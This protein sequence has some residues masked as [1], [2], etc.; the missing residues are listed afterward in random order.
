MVF[1]SLED[2][3]PC[4]CCAGR[5][6]V[7]GAANTRWRWNLLEPTVNSPSVVTSSCCRGLLG[8]L[9]WVI[10]GCTA[11]LPPS[12]ASPR[13]EELSAIEAA[14]CSWRIAELPWSTTC[15]Q[16]FVRIRTVVS[17]PEEFTDLCGRRPVHAGGTLYACN[18]EQH[19]WT[20][21]ASLF[22]SDRIPLLVISRLQP[23]AHRRILVIHESMHWLERCSGK[24]IDFDH[25]DPRVWQSA[26]LM[27]QHLLEKDDERYRLAGLDGDPNHVLHAGM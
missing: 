17:G 12:A 23:E 7:Q 24:G 15:Q 2:W 20:F 16:E 21:P 4:G 5:T 1:H 6:T 8:T 14:V 25:E 9:L 3:P 11:A 19:E 22:D 27:A 10:A 13:P 18:T 26:R